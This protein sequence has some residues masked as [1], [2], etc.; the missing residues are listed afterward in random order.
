MHVFGSE[1]RFGITLVNALAQCA[2]RMHS[3]I[4]LLVKK[5]NNPPSC[6]ARLKNAG[7]ASLL[8]RLTQLR[9][10]PS[11]PVLPFVA[12]CLPRTTPSS[13]PSIAHHGNA[14]LGSLCTPFFPFLPLAFGIVLL[15]GFCISVSLTF[16][17]LVCYKPN[18]TGK[19]SGLREL[20]FLGCRI[21]SL[22][23]FNLCNS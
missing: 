17:H 22:R 14:R 6:N 2:E 18:L 3:T 13:P 1:N 12:S 4:P 10:S 15:L 21:R 23:C 7:E 16:I 8:H 11:I 5:S 20:P 9:Q 19:V